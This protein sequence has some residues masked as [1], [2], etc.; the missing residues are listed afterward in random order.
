MHCD[1][2]PE[3]LAYLFTKGPVT[4]EQWGRYGEGQWA[5]NGE[6]KERIL[7]ILAKNKK[8]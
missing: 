2:G 6:E 3:E 8:Q 5:G 7:E 1:V 4:I